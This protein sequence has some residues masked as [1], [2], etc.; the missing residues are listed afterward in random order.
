MLLLTNDLIDSEG[1]KTVFKHD[2]AS[3]YIDG[4]YKPLY[5]VVG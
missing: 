4:L 1:L 5:Q 2:M 3:L